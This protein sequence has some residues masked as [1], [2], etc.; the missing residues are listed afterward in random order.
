MPDVAGGDAVEIPL[1]EGRFMFG[2]SESMVGNPNANP[3]PTL[4]L[5]LTP[6]LTPYPN[7]N[8]SPS[9][10]PSPSPTPNQVG[11]KTGEVREARVTFPSRTSVPQ[12]AGREAIFEVTCLTSSNPNPSPS[13]DSGQVTCLTNSSPNPNPNPHPNPGPNSGQ[14]TCL[15]VQTRELPE[16]D[17]AFAEK[18]MPGRGRYRGDVGRC[19]EI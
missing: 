11:I 16:C 14:V 2:L 7:P 5:T 3:N 8:P 18:V 19:R 17:D 6:T 9:P 1:V 10:S 13:P 15:K 12:L 4:T